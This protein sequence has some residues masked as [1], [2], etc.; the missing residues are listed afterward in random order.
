[1]ISVS[2]EKWRPFIWFLV[3]GTGRVPTGPD[4]E[5]RVGDQDIRSPGR[6]GS[7]GLQVPGEPNFVFREQVHIG[8]FPADFFL[9]NVLQLHQ[10]RW[11]ILSDDS[12]VL[13]KIINEGKLFLSEKKQGENFSA[14][15]CRR[16]FCGAAG[17]AERVNL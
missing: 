8:E 5:K 12:L 7:R 6:T 16:K 17:G 2:E 10:Q 11:V 9:L 3:Q 4:P 1:M 14:I 15:F 13:W